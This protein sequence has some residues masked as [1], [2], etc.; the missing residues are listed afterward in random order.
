MLSISAQA[1]SSTR[2]LSAFSASCF[3]ASTAVGRSQK[4]LVK[5]I[6]DSVPAQCR[7]V[8]ASI[9]RLSSLEA[10]LLQSFSLAIVASS[11]RKL[12][13]CFSI[14]ISRR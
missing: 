8:L 14:A 4:R 5:R 10:S 11:C 12:E 1:T 13:S 9:F 7:D 6:I 2:A 3:H